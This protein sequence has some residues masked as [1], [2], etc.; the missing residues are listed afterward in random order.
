MGGAGS[1]RSHV[2]LQSSLYLNNFYSFLKTC[3]KCHFSLEASRLWVREPCPCGSRGA[4][5]LWFFIMPLIPEWTGFLETC[6]PVISSSLALSSGAGPGPAEG[7]LASVSLPDVD[8]AGSMGCPH[9]VYL[10]GHR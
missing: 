3:F 9:T 1:L 2:L 7:E 8:L 10:L 4:V 6:S 5:I